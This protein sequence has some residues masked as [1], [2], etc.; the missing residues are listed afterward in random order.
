MIRRILAAAILA[1][2]GQSAFAAPIT[3]PQ[4]V[5]NAN[6]DVK[7]VFVFANALNTSF[8]DQVSPMG[9]NSIF[10]NHPSGSCSGNTSG[11]TADLGDQS[12][13]L[14]F[15]L[16]N[17]STGKSYRSDMPDS[18]GNY[19]AV[20]SSDYASFGLGALPDT[21]AAAL[22]GL[23]NITFVA[24]EDWDASNGSDFDYN[25]LVFAFS[26]TNAAENPDV[27]EPL[28]LALLGAGLLGLG[29]LRKR[30]VRR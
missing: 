15:R 9:W 17:I 22:S 14:S 11:D 3:T 19:H 18:D 29:A 7:A 8:L 10:C 13:P 1:L 24:W 16:R 12:G 20:F 4:P 23:S 27:P 2:A 5:L 6:G 30:A 26:N 28:S 25:D 21:A